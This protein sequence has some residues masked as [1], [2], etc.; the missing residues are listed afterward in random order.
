MEPSLRAKRSNLLAWNE[1][2]CFS[3]SSFAM[4]YKNITNP[5]FEAGEVEEN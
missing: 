5:G 2:D 1:T 4:T 3:R